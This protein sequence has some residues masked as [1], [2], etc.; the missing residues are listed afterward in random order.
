MEIDKLPILVL[1]LLLVSLLVGVGIIVQD[2]FNS[3]SKEIITLVN[4][5]VTSPNSNLTVTLAKAENVT[6]ITQIVNAS[7]VGHDNYTLDA[8]TGIVTWTQNTSVCPVGLTCYVTYTYYEY[9]TPTGLVV[10]SSRDAI[11]DIS[12]TWMSLI[13]VVGVLAIIIGIVM[14]GFMMKQR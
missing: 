8:S 5:S 10:W 11:A 3:G 6:G 13:V 12:N 2:Q 14:A 9:S 1:T 4:E 7:N